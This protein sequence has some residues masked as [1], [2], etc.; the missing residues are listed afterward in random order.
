MPTLKAPILKMGMRGT[1]MCSRVKALFS[2]VLKRLA[3]LIN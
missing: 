1:S 2:T 3:A